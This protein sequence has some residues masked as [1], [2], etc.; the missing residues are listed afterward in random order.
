MSNI[1]KRD[2][3]QSIGQH[4]GKAKSW[5]KAEKYLG[6]VRK[7]QEEIVKLERRRENELLLRSDKALHLTGLPR[8]DSPDLQREQTRSVEIDELEEKKREAEK[9]LKALQEEVGDTIMEIADPISQKILILHYI[10][11]NSWKKVASEVG[12]STVHMRRYRDEGMDELEELPKIIEYWE[13]E[14]NTKET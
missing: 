13:N 4:P 14:C 10:Q 7:K 8:S 12:Y 1:Y 2:D 5:P 6:Q 3:P 11:G 9:E